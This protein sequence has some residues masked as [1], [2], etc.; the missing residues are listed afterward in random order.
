MF[1]KNKFS[2][3]GY[4]FVNDGRIESWQV[5]VQYLNGLQDMDIVDVL[6]S[7]SRVTR[8]RR[9]IES[10]MS[11]VID[12][13]FYNCKTGSEVISLAD[14]LIHDISTEKQNVF[15]NA[16]FDYKYW[17]VDLDLLFAI[18]YDGTTQKKEKVYRKACEK[19]YKE[20]IMYIHPYINGV[21]NRKSILC[22]LFREQCQEKG[23][24]LK[25]G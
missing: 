8:S 16:I 13:V 15:A 25:R 23:F 10:F 3:F 1:N 4:E 20:L 24:E 2:E 7:L 17:D 14:K 19:L 9:V 21:L 22:K 5:I 12:S 18:G 11:P 6:P